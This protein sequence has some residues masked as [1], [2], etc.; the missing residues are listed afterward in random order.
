M[1]PLI[2]V[3]VFS[4]LITNPFT[5]RM[6]RGQDLARSISSGFFTK[7]V[8]FPIMTSLIRS[9]ACS[10]TESEESLPRLGPAGLYDRHVP[11]FVTVSE[12]DTH[13]A[14]YCSKNHRGR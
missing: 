9:R 4:P 14:A 3:G 2:N 11:E 10:K 8:H 1:I 13:R 5:L 7:R 12:A 6:G